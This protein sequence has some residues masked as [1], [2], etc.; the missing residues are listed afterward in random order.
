MMSCGGG[1]GV[2]GGLGGG[3]L[4]NTYASTY[5]LFWCGDEM[6]HPFT[7]TIRLL[8]LLLLPTS[9]PPS[10]PISPP[11]HH[12]HP[13]PSALTPNPKPRPPPAPP[14]LSS[15]QPILSSQLSLAQSPTHNFRE[16]LPQDHLVATK[17][18]PAATNANF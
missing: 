11:H 7:A 15:Y 4:C 3:D 9:S 17:F 12:H 2:E 16:R 8:F 1:W 13:A 18:E 14:H 10:S 6:S 5:L